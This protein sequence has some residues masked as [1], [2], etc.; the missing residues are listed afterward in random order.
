M[1]TTFHNALITCMLS[2]KGAN[3]PSLFVSYRRI[4]LVSSFSKVLKSSILFTCEQY[5][6][7][8]TTN[9]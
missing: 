9:L 5:F 2:P 6:K 3:D 8:S 7:V 1:P 4:D